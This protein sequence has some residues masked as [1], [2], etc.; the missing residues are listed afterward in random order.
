MELWK[1]VF[2]FEVWMVGINCLSGDFF[3]IHTILRTKPKDSDSLLEKVSYYPGFALV[4]E[5]LE[6][7]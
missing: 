7:P 6:S 1:G 4:L 3:N 2:Y 5:I